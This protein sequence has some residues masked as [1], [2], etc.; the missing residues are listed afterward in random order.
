MYTPNPLD[1]R[2]PRCTARAE[3][4][5]AFEFFTTEPAG[6]AGDARPVHRWGDWYV[7]ERFP[8]LCPW[9]APRGG[10]ANSIVSGPLGG[11]SDDSLHRRGSFVLHER[12]VVR[13]PECHVVAPHRLDWPKD[14]YFRWEIRG[15]TLWATDAEHA[16]VLLHY[17]E[18][19]RRDPYKYDTYAKSL[20]RLP[21]PA[22]AARNR[23]LVA[24][25]IRESLR[26]AALSDAL[27][28]LRGRWRPSG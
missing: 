22:I 18:S 21:A 24:R 25:R 14:A 17:V 13:C 12:G 5:E 26:E 9:R 15:V 2:C 20:E 23:A 3:F 27:P 4:E 11:I 16:R 28:P 10:R 8:S 7:R 6:A 1:V 19:A